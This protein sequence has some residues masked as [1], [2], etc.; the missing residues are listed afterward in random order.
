M[1]VIAKNIVVFI[2]GLAMA[3]LLVSGCSCTHSSTDRQLDLKCKECTMELQI[4]KLYKDR[5][6]EKEGL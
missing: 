6:L 4:N 1:K 2:V 3:V 5:K